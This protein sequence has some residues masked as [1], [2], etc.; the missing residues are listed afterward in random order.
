MP[1]YTFHTEEIVQHQ[2]DLELVLPVDMGESS[3]KL[4]DRMAREVAKNRAL[5]GISPGEKVVAVFRDGTQIWP[6]KKTRKSEAIYL[7]EA[8]QRIDAAGQEEDE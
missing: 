3:V 7:D 1:F 6:R 2:Q 8:Q 4:T 5:D